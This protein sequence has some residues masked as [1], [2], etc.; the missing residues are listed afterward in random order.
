ME[1]GV[2]FHTYTRLSLKIKQTVVVIILKAKCL[3]VFTK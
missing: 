3:H 2:K 1:K